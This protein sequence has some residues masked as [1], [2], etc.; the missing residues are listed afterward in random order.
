[1]AIVGCTTTRIQ[2]GALGD[3]GAQSVAGVPGTE[4]PAAYARV[5]LD[6]KLAATDTG[7]L[8]V[9]LSN[10]YVRQ[11]HM[12]NLSG[13]G[14]D[15]PW[16]L[17]AQVSLS[18]FSLSIPIGTTE[19]WQYG[20][21][22]NYFG[23]WEWYGG[24]NSADFTGDTTFATVANPTSE[25]DAT[26]KGYKLLP[27]NMSQLSK[28]TH[29]SGGVITTTAKLNL[30]LPIL[31]EWSSGTTSPI[32]ISSVE[33][34]VDVSD[35][36]L[37]YPFAIRK[38]G[39]MMSADRTGGF[40]RIRKSSRWRDVKNSEAGGTQ[41]QGLVRKNGSWTRAPRIGAS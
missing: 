22:N 27:F 30:L 33:F 16:H 2:S 5:D 12:S 23:E 38:S 19:Y 17:F 6:V 40:T 39:R 13:S 32:T 9:A 20:R 8:Y 31:Y 35:L 7:A 34:S 4:L 36:V 29:E 10:G 25:S 18:P 15:N 11:L 28:E 24:A 1:M 37:Y 14:R 21:S 41:Q 3:K 26:S